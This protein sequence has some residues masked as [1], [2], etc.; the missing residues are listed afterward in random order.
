MQNLSVTLFRART[1]NLGSCGVGGAVDLVLVQRGMVMTEP[2][3]RIAEGEEN[4]GINSPTIQIN[5]MDNLLKLLNYCSTVQLPQ[6]IISHLEALIV[7][8][9]A[10]TP[11]K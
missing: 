8:E 6:R 4:A 7:G 2:I 9:N 3:Q 11:Q 10:E 1:N 5:R